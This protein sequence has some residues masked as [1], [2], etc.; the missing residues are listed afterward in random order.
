MSKPVKTRR[1]ESALRKENAQ[2]TRTRI[3]E[4]AAELF[5]SQG[6]SQTSIEQIAA[7][8]RVARPTVYSAFS[9]KSALL[10]EALDLTL[11]G[12]DAPI[13]VRDRPWFQEML[14]QRDQRRMLELEARN[15][16]MINERVA[17]LYESVRNAAAVDH[18][19][20]AL[21]A[22]L[23]Q[24]RLIGA[25]VTAEAVSA[26]GPL[27]DNLDLDATLDV[28]WLLKDPAL[29]TALVTDRGWSADRYES[30]LATTMQRLL[31]A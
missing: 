5:A 9:G 1:Y 21:Y 25:R 19:I 23:K 30:W 28:L 16:R 26:L 12:D 8:A 6:Y 11:A 27:R 15:N 22:T 10:K 4:A 29:W 13:P 7:R 2:A 31:L 14:Q 24:Q 18:E 17:P 20:A 3:A